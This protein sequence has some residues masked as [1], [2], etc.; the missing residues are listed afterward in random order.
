MPPRVSV[1]IPAY[2]AAPW[3]ETAVESVRTQ[4][5]TDWEIVAVDDASTDATGSILDGLRTP[6]IHV[7]HNAANLGMTQNWN[8]CLQ[9]AQGALVLKLDADD[10]LKP[11]ALELLATAMEEGEVAAAGIRSMQCDAALDPFDGIQ[12]DDVM[13]RHGIDPYRDS[14]HSS[15]TWYDIA[16]AGYQLW[17]SSAFMVR[18]DLLT[19]LGGWDDRFGCASD[20]EL[21]W[22]VMESGRPIAHRGAV[23]ALYR[24]RPG[25]ISDE[26]RSRGWLTWE[27]AAANLL[28]LS[29]VRAKQPLRRALRMHY[30]RLWERWRRS[31]T[32]LPPALEAR[33]QDVIR[34]VP[35]PPLADTLMTRMRDAV[36]AA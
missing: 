29:R 17:S 6:R 8:R 14:V 10:A 20:T 13:Q 12:G 30:V 23:G 2:N 11:R 4:T 32:A 24:V 16:G 28:S 27:A 9:N 15:A 7:H 1:L 36:S 21:M 35:P 26:Y 31:T 3:I 33:L 19:T 25:S 22:R 34:S 5:W 18:R